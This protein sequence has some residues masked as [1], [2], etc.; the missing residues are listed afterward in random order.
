MQAQSQLR[1]RHTY[2]HEMAMFIHL[3]L[4]CPKQADEIKT[5]ALLL[6]E[7]C[8]GEIC[9]LWGRGG[10]RGCLFLPFKIMFV[11][12]VPAELGT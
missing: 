2:T 7:S 6:M 12:P 10:V 3:G 9:V 4:S 8:L 1:E 5:P 11:F